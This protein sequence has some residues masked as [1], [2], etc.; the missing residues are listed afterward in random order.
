MNESS[1]NE[2]CTLK[3]S[4]TNQRIM[5]MHSGAPLKKPLGRGHESLSHTYTCTITCMWCA[6]L[7]KPK[8]GEYAYDAQLTNP[9]CNVCACDAQLRQPQ[10]ACTLPPGFISGVSHAYTKQLWFLSGA[11]HAYSVPPFAFLV[12]CMHLMQSPWTS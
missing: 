2:S 3:E 4:S 5:C 10:S 12:V 6:Q 1:M 7:M 8:D 9:T 11:S